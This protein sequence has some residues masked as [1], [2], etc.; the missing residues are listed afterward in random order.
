MCVYVC[1]VCGIFKKV[2]QCAVSEY[3]RLL[4]GMCVSISVCGYVG[5]PEWWCSLC[6]QYITS[7]YTFIYLW[8][9]VWWS[10]YGSVWVCY[11]Y[12]PSTQHCVLSI[13][14]TLDI[15]ELQRLWDFQKHL[16]LKEPLSG[17]RALYQCVVNHSYQDGANTGK[18]RVAW[19]ETTMYKW[20][21]EKLNRILQRILH[22][23]WGQKQSYW[24]EVREPGEGASRCLYA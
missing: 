1:V 16:L 17:R 22:W 18:K 9:C 7:A 3:I 20:H 6:I 23:S 14:S 8:I 19:S 10:L 24:G 12:L 5:M 13:H 2:L 4:G 15:T 11:F 21:E